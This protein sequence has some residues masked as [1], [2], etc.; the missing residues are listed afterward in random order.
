MGSIVRISMSVCGTM[1]AVTR[2]PSVSISMVASAVSATLASPEMVIRVRILMS[3]QRI[4]H[5]VRMETVS[6]IL[7][8][9]DVNVTW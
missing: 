2:M 3:V 5:C 8:H 1:V 9:S 4:Q 7:D 6:T